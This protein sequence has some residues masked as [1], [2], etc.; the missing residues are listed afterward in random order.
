MG[1]YGSAADPGHCGGR[2]GRGLREDGLAA[3]PNP[4]SG[5]TV[6]NGWEEE[7]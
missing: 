4:C 3:F 6:G 1:L 5:L 7:H 2:R